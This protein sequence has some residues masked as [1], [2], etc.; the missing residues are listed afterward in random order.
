M[1]VVIVEVIRYAVVT[2]AW[3]DSPCRSSAIVLIEVATIDWSRAARNIPSSRPDRIVRTWAWLY[4]PLSSA[5]RVEPG[6][7]VVTAIDPDP[8]A[9][10]TSEQM[11]APD[12]RSVVG[13]AQG[14]AII[15]R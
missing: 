2:H 9:C 8:S 14:G 11:V 4:S 13:P 1:G 12:K 15:G 7:G 6:P 3:T 10:A 5:L